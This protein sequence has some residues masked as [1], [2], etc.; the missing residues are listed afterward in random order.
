MDSRATIVQTTSGL[1]YRRGQPQR[2]RPNA[3]AQIALY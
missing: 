2:R 1:P 3:T